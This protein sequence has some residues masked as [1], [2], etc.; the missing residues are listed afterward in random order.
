MILCGPV[1]REREAELV[2][3]AAISSV[4]AGTQSARTIRPIRQRPSPRR[5]RALALL[6]RDI[7]RDPDE[8]NH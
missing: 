7:D 2:Y 6:A 4:R 1:W 5:L 8:K 3:L